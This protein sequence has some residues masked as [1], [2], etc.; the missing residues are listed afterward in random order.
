MPYAVA[1]ITISYSEDI[2]HV[3]EDAVRSAMS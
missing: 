2:D 1:R 3:V